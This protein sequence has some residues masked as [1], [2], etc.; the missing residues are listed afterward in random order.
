[1]TI[2]KHQHRFGVAFRRRLERGVSGRTL[3]TQ[4]RN[5]VI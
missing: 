3:G 2:A 1:V 5:F 4:A